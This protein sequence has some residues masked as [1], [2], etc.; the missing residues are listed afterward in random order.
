M[1]KHFSQLASH[2]P[3]HVYL[4]DEIVDLNLNVAQFLQILVGVRHGNIVVKFLHLNVSL[5]KIIITQ[6]SWK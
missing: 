6:Q 5:L 3:C 1:V 4:F 2:V